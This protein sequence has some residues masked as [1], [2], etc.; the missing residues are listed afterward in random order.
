VCRGMYVGFS[1]AQNGPIMV[2]TKVQYRIEIGEM[3][4]VNDNNLDFSI[5]GASSGALRE[6]VPSGPVVAEILHQGFALRSR[7]LRP[8][9]PPANWGGILAV[10]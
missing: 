10:Q 4:E 2:V 6:I 8:F 5:P 3:L 9:T 7:R 1:T